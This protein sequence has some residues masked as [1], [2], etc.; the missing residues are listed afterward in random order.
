MPDFSRFRREDSGGFDSDF[1]EGFDDDFD[2]GFLSEADEDYQSASQDKYP[3][4]S[5]DA[6]HWR[7]SVAEGADN[8]QD[9]KKAKSGRGDKVDLKAAFTAL[10]QAVTGRFAG[11]ERQNRS[12]EAENSFV[13]GFD[14]A[15]DEGFEP[16]LPK[17]DEEQDYM[18]VRERRDYEPERTEGIPDYSDGFSAEPRYS[19]YRNDESRYM[20]FRQEKPRYASPGINNRYD[21]PSGYFGTRMSGDEGQDFS[22]DE[23]TV[24]GYDRYSADESG[25]TEEGFT[26]ED[27][28]SEETP[29]PEGTVG[30][31]LAAVGAALKKFRRRLPSFRPKVYVIPEPEYTPSDDGLGTP[32]LASDIRRILEEQNKPGETE[33]E[34]ERMRSYISTVSTDTRIRPGDIKA[35]ENIEEVRAAES[36]L[37]DLIN[38]ISSSNERQRSMIGVYEEPPEE[39][40]YNYR[41]INNDRQYF[42]D[43]EEFSFDMNPRYGF[44]SEKKVDPGRKYAEQEYNRRYN[45]NSDDRY[46][47][48]DASGSSNAY[49]DG[50][51]SAEEVFSND[52]I[53]DFEDSFDDGFDDDLDDD[54]GNGFGDGFGSDSGFAG[55]GE[56]G[57]YELSGEDDAPEPDDSGSGLN[58]R[59]NRRR[60]ESPDSNAMYKEG[61]RN[62]RTKRSAERKRFGRRGAG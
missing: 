12:T 31:V 59:K 32:T 9:S 19:D 38:S 24:S 50:G 52:L 4:D 8:K 44:E 47:G 48:D 27:R 10:F 34:Y 60:Y 30:S 56:G 49:A 54:F 23:E 7:D 13:N 46:S 2:D 18:S 14:S 41:G 36:E 11:R 57:E 1:G 40:P 35:P 15:V 51:N 39:D 62:Y 29:P 45:L 21:H 43:M 55:N 53:D 58:R 33:Q 3:P 16:V 28:G 20:D 5:D 26:D 37:Y 61:L 25:A 42:T 6:D 17:P 22:Q